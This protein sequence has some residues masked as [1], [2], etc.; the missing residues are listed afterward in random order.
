LRM[1]LPS[2][3]YLMH[4]KAEAS[5][6]QPD[7]YEV[8]GATI[9]GLP[10]VHIGHN[11]WI[12]WGITAAV[13]DDI[14]LYREKIHRLEPDRYLNDHQWLSMDHRI[15]RIEIRNDETLQK[16]IRSTCHG[17]VISDFTSSSGREVLSFRW[18]AHDPTQEFSCVYGLNCARNWTE[19]LSSLQFQSS[20]TLNY[21]YADVQNNI[22]YSLAGKMPL[23][24]QVPS[25][26]PVEGWK[27]ENEWRG[28]I[29]FAELPR[30]YNPAEGMIAT[31]NNRIVD[32]SYPYYLSHFYEPP[33]RIRRIKEL[34]A[35]KPTLSMSDMS[36]IQMDVVSLH[37]TETINDLR[38][39]LVEVEKNPRLEKFAALLLNWDG[40]CHEESIES[41]L[42]HVFH[43]RLMENLLIPNLGEELFTAY[44]EI[45]NQCL[46]PIGQILKDPGSVWFAGESRKELVSRSLREVCE[47]LEEVLGADARQWR[48]GSIHSL[49]VMHAIGR[50]EA[51]RPLLAVGPLSSPGDGTTIRM[52]FY[53]HSNPYQHII[54]ASLRFIADLGDLRRSGFILPPGQSGHLSSPHLKDQ[55]DLWLN[56]H[57]ICISNALEDS[58]REGSLI[59]E[60]KL[61]AAS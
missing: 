11:R 6:A 25:L 1:T 51:I 20:P 57:R 28:F 35:A 26:L 29:P 38:D 24:S 10:C 59:L 49:T 3:W 5:A 33:Y 12:A 9:P 41:A 61:S 60:P 55:M 2:I 53:R 17:P 54:G 21:V 46:M 48:W 7:G 27:P 58:H 40:R 22:G 34:L 42:F 16:I 8:W 37:A 47:E 4:L 23:R 45:L 44:V 30:L 15:E 39:D 36:A 18:T 19:F 43:H 31:A 52:G 56:G 14:E 32:S 13:C 50:I